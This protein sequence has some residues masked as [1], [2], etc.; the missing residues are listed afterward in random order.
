M[1]ALCRPFFLGRPSFT[2]RHLKAS[3]VLVGLRSILFVFS[4]P[5]LPFRLLKRPR[6]GTGL[7]TT[8]YQKNTQHSYRAP[9]PIQKQCSVP[10]R[11]I[12]RSIRSLLGSH[13][14]EYRPVGGIHGN[15][16]RMN[17]HAGSLSSG[18]VHPQFFVVHTHSAVAVEDTAMNITMISFVLVLEK[19]EA[20]GR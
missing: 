13:D 19:M 7:S 17:T 8:N 15:Q 11:Q 1:L 2:Q 20:R 3:L 6:T 4:D 10:Q 12:Q 14:L 18:V 5:D 9:I 16:K